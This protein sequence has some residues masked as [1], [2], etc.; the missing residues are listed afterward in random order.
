M[1]SR[2][3][4]DAGARGRAPALCQRGSAIPAGFPSLR[5][6]VLNSLLPRESVC[7]DLFGAVGKPVWISD[8]ND[9]EFPRARVAAT[10]GL[11]A[12]FAF[13]ISFRKRFLAVMEFFSREIREPMKIC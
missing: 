3:F 6:H 1:G 8:M 12:A 7:Q 4:L 5:E 9:S 2:R 10:E 13:P 11:H